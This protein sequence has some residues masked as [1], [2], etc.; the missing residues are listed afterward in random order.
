M[1]FEV[2][3]S[4]IKKKK[5]IKKINFIEFSIVQLSNAL[6]TICLKKK[7]VPR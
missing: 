6:F 5:M 2:G 3:I 7:S 1:L 4:E